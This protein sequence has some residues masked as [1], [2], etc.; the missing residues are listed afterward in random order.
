MPWRVEIKCK[1]KLDPLLFDFD[2][3]ED[4]KNS[5]EML[6]ALRGSDII[7]VKSNRGKF[8]I[9]TEGEKLDSVGVPNVEEATGPCFV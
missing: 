3:E 6:N 8:R 7:M 2:D 5:V 9:D 1:E 4:A